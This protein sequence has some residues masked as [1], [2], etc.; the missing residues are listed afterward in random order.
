[1]SE[2][3]EIKKHQCVKITKHIHGFRKMVG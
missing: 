1:M 3:E 2:M